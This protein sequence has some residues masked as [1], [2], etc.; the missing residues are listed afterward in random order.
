MTNSGGSTE[1]RLTR[2]SRWPVEEDAR[3]EHPVRIKLPLVRLH[4][5]NEAWIDFLVVPGTETA[6]DGMVMSIEREDEA[7]HLAIFSATKNDIL[8]RLARSF[9]EMSRPRRKVYFAD[10][11][12][13]RRSYEDHCTIL[14][15]IEE[16]RV[17]QAEQQMN[18]HLSRTT[19]AWQTLLGEPKAAKR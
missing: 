19:D 18:A 6:T 3:I 16:R 10:H 15:A 14:E 7:F 13:G 12:R 11:N 8:L 5:S 17:G 2:L 1:R 9:Y 4:H